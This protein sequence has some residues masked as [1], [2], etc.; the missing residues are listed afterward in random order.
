MGKERCSPTVWQSAQSIAM[1]L[2]GDTPMST[3][4]SPRRPIRSTELSFAPRTTIRLA[5]RHS[6]V[7]PLLTHSELGHYRT[8]A[9]GVAVGRKLRLQAR[10]G[11]GR[12]SCHCGPL[13]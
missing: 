5:Q 10:F 3:W 8:A 2:V 1:A 9:F 11:N 4:L 13:P 6:P 12:N 7:A